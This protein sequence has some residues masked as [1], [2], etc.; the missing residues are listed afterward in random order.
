[1][2]KIVKMNL[3]ISFE[4]LFLSIFKFS[5]LIFFKKKCDTHQEMQD[6]YRKLGQEWI[7][8][9]AGNCWSNSGN[10]FLASPDWPATSSSLAVI[11]RGRTQT[12][13][14]QKPTAPV[15]AA[16]LPQPTTAEHRISLLQHWISTICKVRGEIMGSGWV[17]RLRESFKGLLD[18]FLSLTN[19]CRP[20][21]TKSADWPA[22][23][24][25]QDVE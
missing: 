18:M 7:L 4:I 22:W 1:M 13:L 9:M 17:W 25:K 21:L 5:K 6:V 10:Q 11:G 3:F 19:G 20:W 8:W 2:F 24:Q 14:R 15:Q 16:D 12:S 23:R